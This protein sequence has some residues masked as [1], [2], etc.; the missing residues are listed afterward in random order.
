MDQRRVYSPAELVEL[1]RP[2]PPPPDIA[3]FTPVASTEV[4]PP[5]LSRTSG[6]AFSRAVSAPNDM[7]HRHENFN[8]KM[9]EQPHQVKQ[10]GHRE[11][12]PFEAKEWTGPQR[13]MSEGQREIA[14]FRPQMQNRVE[15]QQFGSREQATFE[16]RR[17]RQP[18]VSEDG[19]GLDRQFNRSQEMLRE[20]QQDVQGSERQFA[21]P[22]E[23]HPENMS[24][25]DRQFRPSYE[26]WQDAQRLDRQLN[27]SQEMLRDQHFG[28]FGPPYDVRV[29]QNRDQQFGQ[30]GP[31]GRLMNDGRDRDP[32][33]GR[34]MQF[35]PSRG[36]QQYPPQFMRY[37][38]TTTPAG[39]AGYPYPFAYNTFMRY[40]QAPVPY[41]VNVPGYP[42]MPYPYPG[43]GPNVRQPFY[44]GEHGEDP[45][46]ASGFPSVLRNQQTM[47]PGR[48]S[49]G[50]GAPFPS[51]VPEPMQYEQGRN[52]ASDQVQFDENGYE[53]NAIPGFFPNDGQHHSNREGDSEFPSA[54]A[55]LQQ[56]DSQPDEG[57]AFPSVL[58]SAAETCAQ[59]H[60]FPGVLPD[61][62]QFNEK[63]DGEDGFPSVLPEQK[64]FGGTADDSN[65][66]PSILPNREEINEFDEAGDGEGFPSVLE[67]QRSQEH[68][69]IEEENDE[70]LTWKANPNGFDQFQ[71]PAT[72]ESFES[73]LGDAVLAPPSQPAFEQEVPKKEP[74]PDKPKKRNRNRRKKN[75]AKN[76]EQPP[77][78]VV[79]KT[80]TKP[81]TVV[82][83]DTPME[84][85]PVVVDSGPKEISIEKKHLEAVRLEGVHHF[86]D[87]TQTQQ[88]TQPAPPAP[89]A[90]PSPPQISRETGTKLSIEKPV[91]THSGSTLPDKP[92]L[93]DV[94]PVATASLP[95][96]PTPIPQRTTSHRQT[97]HRKVNTRFE[98]VA[99]DS[100]SEDPKPAPPPPPRRPRRNNR[101]EYNAD[102]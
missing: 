23:V 31:Q 27:R 64:Q 68:S 88:R 48:G 91:R 65:A 101:F 15:R 3:Q 73:V 74:V 61:R 32:Q 49:E 99:D 66:F 93:F 70:E 16:P 90:P 96:T 78:L 57:D 7:P 13:T 60:D 21:S 89:Q 17:E 45:Q 69:D 76:Q 10:S 46:M 80:E 50:S 52:S 5:L 58:P 62:E 102:D 44:P 97:R 4:Q 79:T 67:S 24:E 98:Y 20:R 39:P 100:D 12:P 86:P 11:T 54:F 82:Y 6:W 22:Y 81:L 84:L 40:P 56:F 37:Q 29:E 83:H 95:A 19:Q 51:V 30:F 72:R 55:G 18:F 41:P 34:Y 75:K 71:G 77:V 25:R 38:P 92:Q 1:F 26:G 63:P 8:P 35:Q 85:R 43:W 94:T 36:P 2:T 87:Q 33:Y 42:Y 9:L 47:P 53:G 28:Q 59:N 14:Q